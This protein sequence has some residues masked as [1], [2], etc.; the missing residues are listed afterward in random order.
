MP[1]R[2]FASDLTDAVRFPM[3]MAPG[4]NPGRPLLFPR[5]ESHRQAA[6]RIVRTVNLLFKHDHA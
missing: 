6:C 5:R 4:V 3:F 2:Y 1:Q